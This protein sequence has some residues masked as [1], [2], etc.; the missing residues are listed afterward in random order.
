MD[1]P[2]G[3]I[4]LELVRE[5]GEDYG[6]LIHEH[7]L[8]LIRE[9]L[10]RVLDVGCAEGAGIDVLRRRGATHVAGIELDESFAAEARKRYDE[11]VCGA[12]PDDL[13]WADESFDTVLCYDILE[14]LYDPWD[15]ARRLAALLKPGG[16]LHL[17]LPNARSKALWLPLLVHGRFRYEPEGVMDVTHVR[18]FGRRDAVE[19]LEAAGLEV[20]SVDH[21]APESRKR[22]LASR[23]TRG[24]IMEF[25]TIQWY[26]LARRNAV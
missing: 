25:L 10:G 22:A 26:V 8:G 21:A 11:V 9:P 20:L 6:R 18:F 14:H 24:R 17:S 2:R 7:K 12:V 4:G 1:R 5:R 15:T 19:L 13:S 3:P 16:Q 23:A